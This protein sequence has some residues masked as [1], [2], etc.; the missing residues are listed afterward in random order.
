LR[1]NGFRASETS[2]HDALANRA[3][4]GDVPLMPTG[5]AQAE[6]VAKRAAA[7]GA[8]AAFTSPLSRCVATAEP[9]GVPVKKEMDLIE[10][11]FGAWEGMTFSEVR[12]Q[13]PREL[14]QWLGSTAASPPDGESF[15]QVSKR[16]RAA[17]AR[18]RREHEGQTVAVVSHVSPIK[19]ILRDALAAGDAFLHRLYLDTAGLSILDIYPDDGVAVRLVND[20]SHL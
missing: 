12:A 1:T 17:V 11:D 10:C 8:Q 15:Q 9:I 5:R 4:D 19:L 2:T 16:V 6:A 20:T 13:F 7:M 3:M 14:R 18:I